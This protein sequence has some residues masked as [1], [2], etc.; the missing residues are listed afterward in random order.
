MGLWNFDAGDGRNLV[1]GGG[2]GML[3]GDARC[4]AVERDAQSHTEVSGMVVDAQDKAL[5]GAV[6][7]FYEDGVPIVRG[8]SDSAGR[9]SQGVYPEAG[10]RYD[11]A[12]GLLDLGGWAMDLDLR[13]GGNRSLTLAVRPAV[14]RGGCGGG[15]GRDAAEGHCGG[16]AA[17]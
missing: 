17:L 7:Q 5:V 12:A 16:G 13:A 1:A 15:A 3:Y 14:P 10:R 4:L 6:L 9:F 2:E 11:L 8:R